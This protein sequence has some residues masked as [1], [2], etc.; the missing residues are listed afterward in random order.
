[1]GKET[2][3][4]LHYP[5]ISSWDVGI[6]FIT[7][8]L[9]MVK[10]TQGTGYTNPY[11]ARWKA[12]AK[13]QNVYFN[14]YHF[15]MAGNAQAQAQHCMSTVGPGTPLMLDIESTTGSSPALTD[16]ISF[17]D[18]YRILGG[19]NLHLCYLPHWYWQGEWGS[20][21]LDALKERSQ[22][23]VTSDYMAYSDEGIGWKGY[24]GLG[25]AA[26]QYSASIN[27]GG[28]DNVD[29]NAFKGSGNGGFDQTLS[30]W[31]LL[32]KTGRM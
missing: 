9:V 3:A 2:M 26:W 16:A 24:G 20:M 10:A 31:D 32:V 8:F 28:I 13:T 18:E 21:S 14:A 6:N 5:D 11:Y 22:W 27:Y 4:T 29:F 30:E 25:V 19:Y 17:I 7:S 1:M 12:Q 23:L 15:L